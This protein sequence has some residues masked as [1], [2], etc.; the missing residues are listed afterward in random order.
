MSSGSTPSSTTSPL[1]VKAKLTRE[2]RNL[3]YYFASVMRPLTF[4]N[5]S[6]DIKYFDT[7]TTNAMI[8]TVIDALEASGYVKKATEKGA[9]YW[10]LDYTDTAL[11]IIRYYQF[12][13][14]MIPVPITFNIYNND[15][16]K[17]RLKS[18]SRDYRNV[19]YPSLTN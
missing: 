19:N 1:F 11:E 7:A 15:I 17:A 18:S 16:T 2:Q 13:Q 14:H 6:Q 4:Q 5:I 12:N 9:E 10:L 8:Q 3:L